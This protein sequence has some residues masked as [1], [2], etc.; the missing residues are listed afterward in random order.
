M[1][2]HR[3][4]RGLLSALKKSIARDAHE[5]TSYACVLR[6][7]VDIHQEPRHRR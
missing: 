7:N 5:T 3:E 6:F 1:R 2:P 4:R